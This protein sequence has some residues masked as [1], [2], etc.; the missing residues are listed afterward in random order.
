MFGKAI[1]TQYACRVKVKCNAQKGH[2]WMTVTFSKVVLYG[3]D[4]W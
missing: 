1:S 3:N 4:M 2:E